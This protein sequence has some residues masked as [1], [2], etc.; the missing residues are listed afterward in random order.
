VHGTGSRTHPSSRA[1]IVGQLATTAGR[2]V[3]DP[4]RP[5]RGTEPLLHR[6]K[7][8][9]ALWQHVDE[10]PPGR[11][12]VLRALFTDNLH[13]YTEIATIT[14]IPPGGIGPTRK[15]A[16]QQNYEKDLTNTNGKNLVIA[17]VVVEDVAGWPTAGAAGRRGQQLLASHGLSD[18]S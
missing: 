2:A 5:C 13:P 16:L 10:L 12:T 15:R 4:H 8:K 17:I 3:H 14:G 6:Q 18:C 9:R 1:N 7:T 11:R